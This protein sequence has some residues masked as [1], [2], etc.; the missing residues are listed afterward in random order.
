[1]PNPA[2]PKSPVRIALPPI[3]Y[4]EMIF[5]GVDP[6]K[7]G[8]YEWRIE[9]V[10]SYIGQYRWHARPRRQ[11]G[12]NVARL[13]GRL[14]YRRSNPEGFRRIHWALAAA[15]VG[16]RII[17]LRFVENAER[18]E[19]NTR[20]QALIAERG[21]LNDPPFGRVVADGDNPR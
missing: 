12:T 2:M 17:D 13:L 8:L 19:L 5:P 15:V 7:R 3:W 1:M 18:P 4:T 6:D 9:G 20:E 11:Y 21:C 16:R 10:G 14:P